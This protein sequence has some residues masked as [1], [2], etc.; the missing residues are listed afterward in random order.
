MD[1]SARIRYDDAAPAGGLRRARG[2]G[3]RR[4]LN[5]PALSPGLPLRF[6]AHPFT[7]NARFAI[8]SIRFTAR[9]V[10]SALE[11]YLTNKSMAC[12]RFD[13]LWL[14]LCAFFIVITFY[15][16]PPAEFI[17]DGA[18]F[19]AFVLV[20]ALFAVPMARILRR[21]LMQRD[22]RAA[23][24]CFAAQ[25]GDYIALSVL[26]REAKFRNPARRIAKLIE[27]DYLINVRLDPSGKAVQLNTLGRQA[28]E[29]ATIDIICP[30]CGG[31][32]RVAP[33]KST[34]CAYCDS[35][36]PIPRK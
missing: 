29:A 32:T 1:V 13:F 35:A 23:A 3:E 11:N 28:R 22:A 2:T 34:R 8:I 10:R 5:P 19:V 9:G 18:S 21:R 33:G 6:T 15:A 12:K 20:L 7:A 17:E 24:R 30:R 36:L 25:K 31:T 27:K 4:R 16:V 14:A 26:S